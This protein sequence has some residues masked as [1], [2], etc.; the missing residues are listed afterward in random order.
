MALPW[1]YLAYFTQPVTRNMSAFC[2]RFASPDDAPDLVRLINGLAEYEQLAHESRPDETT[3]RMQLSDGAIPKIEAL[4]AHDEE[5]GR[6]VGFALFFHSY[7]TFLTNFGLFLEDLFVEPDF[8][9]RGIGLA[10][11][12]NLVGVA[13]E[14][15]CKRLDWNVLNWNEPAISFYKQLGAR[16]LMDWTTM[17]LSAKQMGD[18]EKSGGS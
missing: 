15:G 3:L 17:R 9:G 8:R 14:R 7:S 4:V 18:L 12:K 1:S 2:I 10:L 11:F 13:K 6:C 16:S 5:T